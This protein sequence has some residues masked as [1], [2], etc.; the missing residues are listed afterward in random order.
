MVNLGDKRSQG[1]KKKSLELS[2]KS[3]YSYMKLIFAIVPGEKCQTPISKP[4]EDIIL[5][6]L[7]SRCF[8]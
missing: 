3:N 2:Y 6:L 8:F 1:T 7:D 5:L 4:P